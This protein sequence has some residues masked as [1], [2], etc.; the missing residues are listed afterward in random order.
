MNNDS[1]SKNPQSKVLPQKSGENKILKA[2][3]DWVE[4]FVFSAVFVILLFT[5][6]AR[7][8]TVDGASMNQTLAN[9]QKLVLTNL[10]YTPKHGDIVVFQ[11]N[12]DNK[13]LVK[14]VIGVA[15]D[16]ISFDFEHCKVYRNGEELVEDYAWFDPKYEGSPMRRGIY[17]SGVEITVPDGCIFVLGDNRY[18]SEDSRFNSVGFVT[19]ESVVGKAIF[20]ISPLSKFGK[21]N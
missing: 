4:V 10:F 19:L 13:P 3:F 16:V 15:G 1:V 9:G 2:I 7:V 5:F 17:E 11:R 18:N 8:T 6:V 21:V 12:S 20:R 14:R